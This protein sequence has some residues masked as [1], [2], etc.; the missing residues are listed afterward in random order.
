MKRWY[1]NEGHLLTLPIKKNLILERFEKVR[2]NPKRILDWNEVK[3]T[4]KAL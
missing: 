3:N 1:R 2:K 4:L